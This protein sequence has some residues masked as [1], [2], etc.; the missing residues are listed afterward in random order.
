MSCSS[1]DCEGR[2]RQSSVAMPAGW[3][4]AVNTGHFEATGIITQDRAPCEGAQG[5]WQRRAAVLCVLIG[6]P[7]RTLCESRDLWEG[8]AK[9]RFAVL[10]SAPPHPPPHC[11]GTG[12]SAVSNAVWYWQKWGGGQDCGRREI[13]HYTHW[14]PGLSTLQEVQS[15]PNHRKRIWGRGCVE[16]MH[17][18]YSQQLDTSNMH[19]HFY[20]M[21]SLHNRNVSVSRRCFLYINK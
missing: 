1:L 13:T 20:T 15:L 19:F 11:Q 12:A 3:P 4:Q 7:T 21:Y 17:F 18:R 10:Q 9:G 5:S 16:D 8:R 2:R 14:E 6:S